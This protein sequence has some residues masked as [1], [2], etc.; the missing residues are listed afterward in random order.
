[1]FSFLKDVVPSILIADDD[2]V[3]RIFLRQFLEKENY[4]VTEAEDGLKALQELENS[5]YDLL[6]LDIAMPGMDG[7]QLCEKIT[8]TI[9][10]PPPVI[11]ITAL[12]NDESV[13]RSYSVGAIDYIKKPIHWAVLRNRIRYILEAHNAQRELEKMYENY[14]MILDTAG[15]GICGLDE[16]MC[17]NYIN[18]AALEML[19]YDE[20]EVIGQ[21]YNDIFRVSMPGKGKVDPD[22]CLHFTNEAKSTS[23]FKYQE[24]RFFKKNGH[25]FPVDCQATPIFAGN[26]NRGGVLVFQDVT[27]RQQSENLIRYMAN[28]DS[29]TNLPNRNYFNKRLPQAIAMAKRYKRKLCLLFIDLDRFKPVND[30]Y[31][32]AVGDLVLQKVA[33]RLTAML[34]SSDSICRL[35]GDEFV[36]LLESTSSPEG[37]AMVAKKAIDVLNKPMKIRDHTCSVGASVGVS[38]F[39]DSC[40][41]AKTMISQADI[42]MYRAKKRGRNCFEYY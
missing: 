27:E 25:S 6:L 29:L 12:D 1:M 36:I 28:H 37:C 11:M 9:K 31:G 14:E 24:M 41:D 40:K 35:G 3:I 21:P 13:D 10:N 33:K 19:G 26:K 32:H 23:L 4:R 18:P 7:L 8:K 30:T 2:E 15:N 5:H 42:A 20:Q 34:R 17:I 39:P 22:C 38:I 16:N